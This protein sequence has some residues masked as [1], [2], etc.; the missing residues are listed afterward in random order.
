MEPCGCC[1]QTAADNPELRWGMLRDPNGHR[2]RLCSD[3]IGYLWDERHEF[4]QPDEIP[5]QEAL[6][7]LDALEARLVEKL[8]PLLDGTQ[9]QTVLEGAQ[10]D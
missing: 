5:G 2:W 10:D 4:N 9:G 6:I 7:D 3:C 1:W 8:R